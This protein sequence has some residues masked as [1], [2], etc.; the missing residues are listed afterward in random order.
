MKNT[1][2]QTISFPRTS[3]NMVILVE[4]ECRYCLHIELERRGKFVRTA[5]LSS[6]SFQKQNAFREKVPGQVILSPDTTAQYQL[7]PYVAVDAVRDHVFQ[8]QSF[9]VASLWRDE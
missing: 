7:Y 5:V 2:T 1:T 9:V 8:R 4:E 6:Q 3:C